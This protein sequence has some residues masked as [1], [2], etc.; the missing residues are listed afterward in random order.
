MRKDCMCSYCDGK[1][2]YTSVTEVIPPELS[3]MK[4]IDKLLSSINS[5]S[6]I[7]ALSD[8]AIDISDIINSV[9]SLD[10]DTRKLIMYFNQ[11]KNNPTDD[12]D[13]SMD[14]IEEREDKIIFRYV[15]SMSGMLDRQ[16]IFLMWTKTDLN[17]PVEINFSY[18]HKVQ[19]EK[20]YKVPCFVILLHN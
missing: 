7:P 15:L 17:N 11:L 4:S 6:F 12:C 5:I 18:K 3:S 10:K 16:Y 8:S 19:G 13:V 20:N 2:S 9:S 1:V 14:I